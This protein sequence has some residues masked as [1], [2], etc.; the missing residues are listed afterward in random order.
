MEQAPGLSLVSAGSPGPAPDPDS[1]GRAGGY[2]AALG[3][4]VPGPEG[5]FRGPR[6]SP[7]QGLV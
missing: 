1:P 6:H 2:E 5:S 7:A 4:L 3:G